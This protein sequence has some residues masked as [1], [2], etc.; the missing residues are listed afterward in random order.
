MKV[1]HKILISFFLLLVSIFLLQQSISNAAWATTSKY[2]KQQSSFSRNYS[3][4]SLKYRGGFYIT[5]VSGATSESD[6]SWS[7]GFA[8]LYRNSGVFCLNHSKRAFEES[9]E[10]NTPTLLTNIWVQGSTVYKNKDASSRLEDVLTSSSAVKTARMYAYITSHAPDRAEVNID[11]P[12]KSNKDSSAV[13]WAV[14]MGSRDYFH[15]LSDASRYDNAFINSHDADNAK[16]GESLYEIAK[17]YA[18]INPTVAFQKSSYSQWKNVGGNFVIGPFRVKFPD[19]KVGNTRLA[20]ESGSALGGR[21]VGDGW[22]F[23]NASGQNITLKSG[24]DFY[25]KVSPN[26]MNID[27]MTLTIQAKVIEARAD[28]WEQISV[29]GKQAQMFVP[30]AETYWTYPKASITIKP[31]SVSLGKSD[32]RTGEPLEGIEFKIRNSAGYYL[33]GFYRTEEGTSMAV[34]GSSN[35]NAGIGYIT[36]SRGEIPPIT[37]LET[38]VTYTMVE[39]SVGK[40]WQYEPGQTAPFTLG[41]SGNTNIPIKNEKVFVNISGYVWKDEASDKTED[42]TKINNLYDDGEERLNRVVTVRL[43]KRG[44]NEIVGS[45]NMP[46]Q[47]LGRYGEDGNGEYFFEKVRIKEIEAGNYYI[48]FEY[49][50]LTYESVPVPY[51]ERDNGSKAKENA[52][53][54][55]A[56]NESFAI[57]EGSGRDSGFTRNPSGNRSRELDYDISRPHIATLENDGKYKIT[58]NTDEGGYMLKDR[59]EYREEEMRNINLGIYKREQPDMAIIK[60]LHNVKVAINGVEHTYNY[61]QRFSNKNK[62]GDGFDIGVKFG[63]KYESMSYT[64]AIYQSDYQYLNE[65]DRGK[66]LQVY[67]T[68]E[69]KMRNQSSSLRTKINSVVDYYDNRLEIV[70]VGTDVNKNGDTNATLS[71]NYTTP[72]PYGSSGYNKVI[73]SNNTEIQANSNNEKSIYIQY[74][75][76]RKNVQEIFEG[77]P[78]IKDNIAEINSYSI[79]DKNGIYAGI[80]K[81]S[82]PG[83]CI[84]GDRNTY[85]DDTDQAPSLQLVLQ[86]ERKIEGQVFVDETGKPELQSGKI[87]QANGRNDAQEEKLKDVTVTLIDKDGKTVEI[88]DETQKKWIPAIKKTKEDGTYYIGGFIPDNY[89]IVY[90]WGDKKHRVQEYKSTIVDKSSYETKEGGKT[91]NALEWYKD[92]FKQ[93]Y[94]GVEW[95]N[96]KE[97]RVSDAVDNYDERQKIDDQSVLVTNKNQKVIEAYGESTQLEQTG[98]NEE[99]LITQIN[100]TTPG[101]RINVEYSTEPTK[102]GEEYI[103]D[104]QEK[105]QMTKIDNREY[106]QKKPGQIN[107]LKSIDF[108]IVERARQ[109]IELNKDVTNVKVTLANGSILIDANVVRDKNGNVKLENHVKHTVYLPES[110]AKGQIKMEIDSEIIQGAKLEIT[111]RLRAKNI[112]EVDYLNREFYRYGGTHGNDRNTLVTLNT[113]NVIDYLDNNIAT[114]EEDERALGKIIQE[115]AGKQE[116]IT[117]GL[118]ENSTEMQ[119]LLQK[120][121]RVFL[122]HGLTNK[123]LKPI[124]TEEETQADMSFIAYKLLSNISDDEEVSLE[125]KAEIIKVTKSGGSSLVTITGNYTPSLVKPEYDDDEAEIVTILEPTGL[126]NNYIAYT[127]LGISSLGIVLAGIILIKKFIIK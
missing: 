68:Y 32:V 88:F 127:L 52:G 82:N 117:K 64:R 118:L 45:Y 100:S 108:G 99:N 18:K 92:K 56:F 22:N 89:K 113:N 123:A 106:V 122:M 36:N 66:E 31:P 6:W 95:E 26:I 77:K 49:D 124:G 93:G 116:L 101:F 11:K 19:S 24:S 37:G 20:G 53:V 121:K 107:E 9:E 34:F 69:I 83:N 98:G 3:G 44:T 125:N 96:N 65:Q 80:D 103:T 59:F 94:P 91:D 33:T 54:R 15:H 86:Q 57:V 13:Q 102:Y 58:A 39:T 29:S 55:R 1:K 17:A 41:G 27:G 47:K 25:I 51:V 72:Q 50:G 35:V 4:K 21:K 5:N 90:T 75:L 97:I 61:A 73:I 67:I 119:A 87:R 46:T 16:K 78:G 42:L 60:D 74:R 70:G 105:I 85:E 43:K 115:N 111:Y 8:K 48:E 10:D 2:N 104:S 112:S 126:S 23:C 109:A 120:T 63:D 14:W 62:Y 38:G 76:N 81:N 40:N 7:H 12:G 71:K 114:E 28:W 30:Y 110:A 79:Y 84:P